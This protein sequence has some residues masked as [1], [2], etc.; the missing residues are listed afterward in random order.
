ME[1]PKEALRQ[2]E[3]MSHEE[4]LQRFKKLFGREMTP[5]ERRSFF[6]DIDPSQEKA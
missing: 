5:Q 6:L 4:I 2:K 1:E 3:T